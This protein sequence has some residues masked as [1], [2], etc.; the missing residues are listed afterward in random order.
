MARRDFG[1]IRQLPSGR[2]QVRY[3][4]TDG[5]L[6]PAPSTFER[7]RDA[8]EWL[9]AI[10]TEIGRGDWLDPDR[11]RVTFGEFGRRW[12]DE[13]ELAETTRQ[14]YGYAFR[15]HLVPSF[16][17]RPI[18]EIRESE[19]RTWRKE[20]RDADVGPATIAKSYRLMHA[21]MATAVDDGLTRRNPCRIKGAGEERSEERKALT[22]E[23]VFTSPTRFRPVFGVSCS[24]P[25]SPACDSGS[26][27][28]YAGLS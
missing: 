3:C 10:R 2:W 26:W 23:Q 16:G 27:P 19:I 4:G 6:R 8:A 5:L 25:P 7:K 13:R 17:N 22:V 14:R 11:G 12:L 21:I 28:R 18:A 1:R 15:L 20:R 9:A 24:W